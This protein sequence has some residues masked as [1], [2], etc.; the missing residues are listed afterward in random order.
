M[1]GAELSEVAVSLT[2][3]D[4]KKSIAWYEGA[5]GFVQGERWETDGVLQGI[6]MKSGPIRL[7]LGQDDWKKGRGRQKGEGWRVYF[8]TTGDVDAMAE[9][10][11]KFGARLDGDVQDTSM[12]TRDFSLV[13]PDGFK[14]TIS[15][16]K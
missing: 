14:L 15:R 4:L 16:E 1:A 8:T 12:G 13:D 9:R 7:Y 2:V 6:E 3:D 5:L 10:A 11:R